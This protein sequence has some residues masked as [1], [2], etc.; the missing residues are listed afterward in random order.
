MTV[1][2]ILLTIWLQRLR[3]A[4]TDLAEGRLDTKVDLAGMT[5]RLR[6][7]GEQLNSLSDVLTQAV[8]ERTRSERMKA[9]L[10][11]NVSHDIKT[12]LTSIVNY[13][14]L[15]KKEPIEGERAREYLEILDRQSQRMKKLITDLVDA[16]KASTGNLPT[17][18]EP[19]ALG[20]MLTQLAGEYQERLAAA[21]L[22]LVCDAA[23]EQKVMADA[24]LLGRVFDNLLGNAI[25]YALPGTRVY[26]TARIEDDCIAVELKNVSRE[27]L[28]VSG[29]ELTERFVRGDTSRNTEGSGLGLSI[30]KSLVELQEGTFRVAV[31][32]DL[33]KITLTLPAA[34]EPPAPPQG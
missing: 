14:D 3:R 25:K 23:P 19:I 31:D 12:P 9:E 6:E 21:G 34:A 30:A 2:L 26:L 10:I 18:P 33:F 22:E 17:H 15:L 13:V 16:S 27:R 1:F 32:G 24:R 4:A 7:H 20:L 28:S 29:E 5:P 11:T 8:D